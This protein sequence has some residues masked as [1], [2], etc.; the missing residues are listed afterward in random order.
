VTVLADTSIWVDYLRRG[1]SGRDRLDSLLADGEVVL[2]GP[3]VAELLAGVA[4]QQRDELWRLLSSLPWAEVGR[5]QW[6]RV[7]E[8]ASRLRAGGAT[9]ALTDIEIAVAAADAGA[10][11][12]SA[13][14]DFDRIASELPGLER[15]WP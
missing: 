2:C 14:R 8:V 4:D 15:F 9:T 11:L 13:G 1:T 5:L 10:L 6:R 3:V 12:W 7:G